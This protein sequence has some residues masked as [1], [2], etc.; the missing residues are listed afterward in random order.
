MTIYFQKF[1]CT[2]PFAEISK[3]ENTNNVT[4]DGDLFSEII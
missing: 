2:P 3:P 4:D 1:S